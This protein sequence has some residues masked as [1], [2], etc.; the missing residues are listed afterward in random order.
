MVVKST[1][2]ATENWVQI[3]IAFDYDVGSTG[4]ISSNGFAVVFL[5]CKP[6]VFMCCYVITV[7]VTTVSIYLSHGLSCQISYL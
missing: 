6:L 5:A 4:Q 2:T 1:T 3:W 7:L